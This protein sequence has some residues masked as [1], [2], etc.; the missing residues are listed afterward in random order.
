MT[1]MEFGRE[2]INKTNR[3]LVAYSPPWTDRVRVIDI[4]DTSN[5]K[6][7]QDLSLHEFSQQSGQWERKFEVPLS[8]P[9]PQEVVHV[10]YH[11]H[12][13]DDDEDY[14]ERHGALGPLDSTW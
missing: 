2:W 11:Y 3:N 6:V 10:H 8:F 4:A 1:I 13:D 9:P 7:V 12:E 14:E 5:P